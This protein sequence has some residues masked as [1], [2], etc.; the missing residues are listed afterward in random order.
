MSLKTDNVMDGKVLE[1][2]LVLQSIEKELK[3]KPNILK[4]PVDRVRLDA[5]MADARA[6]NS[7]PVVGSGKLKKRKY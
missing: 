3:S 1:S 7:F 5:W 4:A 2:V 6:A